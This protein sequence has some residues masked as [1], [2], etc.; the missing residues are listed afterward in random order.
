M[1]F[2][3]LNFTAI[4]D[5]LL[6]ASINKHQLLFLCSASQVVSLRKMRTKTQNQ[7][8]PN[9]ISFFSYKDIDD[10]SEREK[11]LSLIVYI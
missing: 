11:Y 2:F 8:Y 1:T 6:F 4:T 3:S 10:Q 5:V 7:T 9:E